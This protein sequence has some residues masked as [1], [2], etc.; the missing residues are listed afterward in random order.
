[1]ERDKLREAEVGPVSYDMSVSVLI[2]LSG[3][4]F[5]VAVLG[6]V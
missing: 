5:I 4:A 2:L 6:V 3:F 1:M